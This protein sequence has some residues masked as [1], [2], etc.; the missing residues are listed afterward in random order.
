MNELEVLLLAHAKQYP[1][2]TATDFCKL[3]Y[4]RE[5]G[6]GHLL[7][8]EG[9]AWTRLNAE[10]QQTQP[11]GT[12]PLWEEL[13]NGFARLHLAVA[14]AQGLDAALIASIFLY[15]AKQSVGTQEGFLQQVEVFTK[16]CRQGLLP[17]T[18]QEAEETLVT[19]RKSGYAP[20]S[21]S[22][23][24]ADAYRPAYRVVQS[25]FV[26]LLP[27]L[28][29][30]DTLQ[31]TQRVLIG[32]D[33]RCGAGKS[34]LAALFG[35]LFCAPVIHTDDFFLPAALR[36]PERLAQPGGNLHRER[37]VEEVLHP[38]QENKAF[39]YRIFDCSR[40][41]Y[42]G[43]AQIQPSNIV[44]IEGAYC[45]HPAFGEPYHYKIFC[46]VDAAEQKQRILA[47]NGA[48]QWQLFETRW[49]PME[50]RYLAT[51]AI[52]EQCDLTLKR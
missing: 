42:H 2:A 32:I 9:Q 14:K 28:Q 19:F 18:A 30:V 31:R 13:G 21:H 5:F 49:I 24:F 52:R 33:G 25:D 51:F 27:C 12:Q 8:D 47:R 48:H 7:C 22:K 41:D 4:Q 44:I 26:E 40:M 11:D 37:F 23:Q 38:L 20:F 29:A 10:W 6:C 15:S 35:E 3:L 34:T 43:I 36:T 50:E 17:C 46:D 1:L 16:L 39:F 45:M